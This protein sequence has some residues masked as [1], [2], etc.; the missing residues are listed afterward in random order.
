M[1]V[2]Y[3]MFAIF[4]QVKGL[5]RAKVAVMFGAARMRENII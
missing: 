2:P 4:V 3:Q 1:L 5:K